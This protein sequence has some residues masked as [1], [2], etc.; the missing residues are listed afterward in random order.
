MDT[1]DA[2]QS[3][4]TWPGTTSATKT[5]EFRLKP[6]SLVGF[7]FDLL[8]TNSSGTAVTAYHFAVAGDGSDNYLVDDVQFISSPLQ[9]ADRGG[10]PLST[11]SDLG[12]PSPNSGEDLRA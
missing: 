12:T 6:T 7:L 11:V 5:L 4:V 1:T 9:V 10:L 3:Q 8:G 2:A